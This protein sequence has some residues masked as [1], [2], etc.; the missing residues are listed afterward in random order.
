[1]DPLQISEVPKTL[2]QRLV[3]A[4]RPMEVL[5]FSIGETNTEAEKSEHY[6]PISGQKKVCM[7]IL[8]QITKLK[9]A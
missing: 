9:Q 5:R 7:R 6:S 4:A 3:E 1:M 2:E 8:F